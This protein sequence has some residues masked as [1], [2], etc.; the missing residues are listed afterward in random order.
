MLQRVAKP[1]SERMTNLEN[2]ELKF[3]D[4]IDAVSVAE[5]LQNTGSILTEMLAHQTCAVSHP[6]GNI[7]SLTCLSTM[8]NN[9]DGDSV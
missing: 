7:S 8:L 5:S 6:Y 9:Q 1:R 2:M 4:F 3:Q